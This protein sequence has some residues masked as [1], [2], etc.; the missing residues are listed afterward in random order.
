MTI[1]IFAAHPDDETLGAGATIAKLAKTE[2]VHVVVLGDG[3][4][5]RV[6]CRDER[7]AVTELYAD[8]RVATSALGVASLTCLGLPDLRFDTLPLLEIVWQVEKVVRELRPTVIYTHHQG[9][10]NRDHELT[11][12]AVLTATRPM[13]DCPVADIYAF[14]VPSSTEW[15]FSR[16]GPPFRPNVFVDV[17]DSIDQKVHAME[18]Y[19]SERRDFPHPRSGEALRAIAR[20]WGSVVGRDYVEAFELLR[21]VRP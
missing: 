4:T 13:S 9:D 7:D 10:L 16:S 6:E 5:A 18:C 17:T 14:E 11:A 20:R 19:R 1:A 21:S 12:R 2:D 8:A 15:A 3:I